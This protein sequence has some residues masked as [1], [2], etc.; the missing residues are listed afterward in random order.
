[1]NLRDEIIESM[2]WEGKVGYVRKE[3][4][5]NELIKSWI[6]KY[7]KKRVNKVVKRVKN[8][9]FLR[10][11]VWKIKGGKVD[12]CF[13]LFLFWYFNFL[14]CIFVLFWFL[15]NMLVKENLFISWI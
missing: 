15:K 11:K 5:I 14:N 9:F 13:L 1:M 10:R 8:C 6:Y 7:V 2:I 3:S 12:C 4:K